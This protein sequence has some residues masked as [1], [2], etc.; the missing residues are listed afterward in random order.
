MFKNF[1]TNEPRHDK[2]NKV[3]VRPV[4][5][6]APFDQS[7]LCAKWVSK[8]PSLLH[9]DSEDSDQTGQMPRLI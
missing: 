4:K 2:T 3:T 7:S 1:T 8:D 5:T 6:F 9:A